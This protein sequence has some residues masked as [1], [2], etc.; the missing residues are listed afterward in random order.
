MKP[1]KQK[2]KTFSPICR[3][4]CLDPSR[5]VSMQGWSTGLWR[6]EEDTNGSMEFL[7]SDRRCSIW[8]MLRLELR[9]NITAWGEHQ[10]I[11][12]WGM[13]FQ[14]LSE[15]KNRSSQHLQIIGSSGHWID[16]WNLS[17]LRLKLHIIAL[18]VR[19]SQSSVD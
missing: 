2:K 7:R 11:D 10:I 8:R 19:C 12:D 4:D 15:K 9:S 5:R 3:P 13:A 18:V 17:R 1:Q 6:E 16:L 14:N